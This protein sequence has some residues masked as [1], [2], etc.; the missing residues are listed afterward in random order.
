MVKW[1]RDLGPKCRKMSPTAQSTFV[2]DLV[3]AFLTLRFHRWH[4]LQFKVTSV[5][6]NIE[7]I[8]V[9]YTDERVKAEL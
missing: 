3:V 8:S 9:Y 5:L 2:C 6:V 1:H 4:L 7:C